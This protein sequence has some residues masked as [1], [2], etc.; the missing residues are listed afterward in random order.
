[1]KLQWLCRMATIALLISSALMTNVSAQTSLG[2][3]TARDVVYQ[4]LTDRFVDGDATNNIPSGSPSAIFDGTGGDLKLYQGGDWQGITDK[5]TYLKNMGITVVWISAPY[6]NRDEAI[7]DFQSGGGTLTWSSYHGYHA[8]NYFRTNSHFGGM[9]D[10]TDMVT[11]LHAEGIKVVIDFV[12]NHTSRWQNPT[13]GFSAEN[14]KLFEP[15][16]NGSGDFVFDTNGDPVDLN[17]DGSSD[18]LLA[19]PNGT[20]NPGWFHNLG[21]RG[22]DSSRYGFRYKEL[23]SLAD[24]THELPE[25]A[26]HLEEAAI[27]WKGKGIDGFRHDATLH[28]NPAFAKSFRDAIDSS[29]GGAVTHFGEFFIGKPDP[30]Y[31]EYI[32]FPDRTGINNLDFEYFRTLTNVIG[33]GTDDM[34]DLANFYDYTEDDYV[35]ENQTVTFIDNHDVP[36]FLR[37]NSDTRS[38]DVALAITLVSRGIPNIYYGTEQYVDGDDATENGGRVFMET[39]TTFDETTRAFKIIKKLSDVRQ[40]NDAVAF[41]LTNVLYSTADVMVMSRKFF[42]KEVII[43]VNRSP[44]NSYVV[45]AISTTLPGGTYTDEL[46]GELGGASTTVASGQIPTFT[47]SQ[48]EVAVW[49]HNPS[50]GANPKLGDMQSVVGRDGDDVTIYGTGLDGTIDVKFGTTSATVVSNSASKVTVTVPNV[51]AGETT[52]TVVKGVNTSNGFTFNVLSNDQNMMIFHAVVY[53]SPGQNVYVVGNTPEL[54]DWDPDNAIDAFHNPNASEWWKW[55]LPVSVPASTSLEYKFILKDGSGNV[56]WESGSNRTATTSSDATGG[57]VDLPE[58][59][60]TF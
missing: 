22:S 31:G 23:G 10:F 55:F 45:P 44:F 24:F 56:T 52:V 19:D 20:T 9:K 17:S 54:G 59:T 1:M 25:V 40:S 3:V 51:S 46:D 58:V 37:V 47:L 48:Q 4:I 43:A 41:G 42:D 5:I 38:L 12:S 36:R 14:G 53:T 32:T 18:N 8:S 6:A 21:D 27:F 30:K 35:Y 7:I 11:A 16:R 60:P 26:E 34:I 29:S 33:N 50:L 15:D 49:S 57:V 28:M 39:D 2:P 13:N